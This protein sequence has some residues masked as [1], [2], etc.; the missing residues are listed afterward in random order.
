MPKFYSKVKKIDYKKAVSIF[1]SAI[2][3]FQFLFLPQQALAITK[4]W[5]FSTS[6]DYTF[7]NTKI[8]FSSGQAQL[9]ATSTPVAWYN[10]SW[11]YRRKITFDNSA[12][13]EKKR[14][15]SICNKSVFREGKRRYN[16]TGKWRYNSNRGHDR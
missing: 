10:I 1:L 11:G 16:S 4:A 13:A 8:E 6:S 15:Q 7:D 12:Q 5:D 9:K 3:I 14:R 2:L